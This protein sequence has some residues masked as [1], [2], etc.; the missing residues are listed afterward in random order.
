VLLTV[1]LFRKGITWVQD[2]TI[3][4]IQTNEDF[5]EKQMLLFWRPNEID[6]TKDRVILKSLSDRR[7][8]YLLKI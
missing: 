1:P 6:V 7:N 4:K 8:L 5:Y 2:M 3:K